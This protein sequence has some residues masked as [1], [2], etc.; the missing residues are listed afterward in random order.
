[1]CSSG[2]SS[3]VSAD[4]LRSLMRDIVRSSSWLNETLLRDTAWKS[5]TGMLTSPKLIVPFQ[6]GR[7]MPIVCPF[8]AKSET[9][10]ASRRPPVRT[11]SAGEHRPRHQI[12]AEGGEDGQ[13]Q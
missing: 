1:M 9:T 6:T 10:F 2:T 12:G 13:V 5:L 11:Q 8:G 4:T 3:P 7:G